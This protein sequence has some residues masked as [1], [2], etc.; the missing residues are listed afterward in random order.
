M[1]KPFGSILILSGPSGAGKS[2]LI[3]AASDKIGDYYFSISTTTRP[4]R[5]GEKNGVDYFFVSKEEF[6][7][8][9]RA[10]EFLEYAQVHG[11]Y[12]GTSLKPVREALEQGKLVIFDIDVQGHA[13]ARERMGDLITSV[14]VTTPSLAELERRLRSRGTDDEEIIRKRIENALVE[15]EYISAYDFL[16]VNDEF[17]QALDAFVAVAKA[18]RLKKGRKQALQFVNEWRSG[19]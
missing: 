1:S 5:E 14:F 6:E 10:G 19:A 13:I 4:P 9:I 18:A 8:D 17:D 7:A 15:I 12:Y 3:K 2:S 11:N 16:I